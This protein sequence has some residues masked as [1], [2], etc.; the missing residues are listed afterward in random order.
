MKSR[1]CCKARGRRERTEIALD[2]SRISGGPDPVT[3]IDPGG[4]FGTSEIN[5][6]VGDGGYEGLSALIV[7]PG[8]N[9][10][11]NE[12]IGLIFTGDVPPIP[13][14]PATE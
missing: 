4:Q 10:S 3:G 1:S 13:A 5:L 14:P 9:S 12:F 7:W 6:C 8:D 11:V 2:T